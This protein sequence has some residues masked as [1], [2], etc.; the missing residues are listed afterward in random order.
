MKL[1]LLVLP[2]TFA[3]CQ[4]SPDSP[5]PAWTGGQDFLVM[6]R[7]IDELSVVCEDGVVPGGVIVERGWR[8]LKV[9]GPLEFSLVGVLASLASTLADAGVSIFAISTYDTDYLLVKQ[10]DLARAITALE[11]AGNAVKYLPSWPQDSRDTA[12]R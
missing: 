10:D 9:E 2:K 3:V 8:A 11:G 6:V 7:T 5:I 1:S 4:L 12:V